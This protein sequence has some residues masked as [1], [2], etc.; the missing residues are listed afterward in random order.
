MDIT[1]FLG[2]MLKKKS[3]GKKAKW[4]LHRLRGLIE[5]DIKQEFSKNVKHSNDSKDAHG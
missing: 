4:I 1:E 5:Y 2:C 3:N